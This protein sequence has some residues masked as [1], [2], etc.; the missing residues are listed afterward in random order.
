MILTM[1]YLVMVGR[2]DS[3]LLT[4]LADRWRLV[5]PTMLLACVTTQR[6][7]LLLTQFVLLA[8]QQLGK[9]ARHVSWNCRLVPYRSGSALGGS[10]S[11]TV[12]V[13]RP[14]VGRGPLF[15]LRMRMLQLGTGIEGSLCPI[16][17]GLTLKGPVV[18]V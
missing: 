9:A 18:T 12:T 1:V 11:S 3:I 13:F 5:M 6:Q 2:V 15:L 17:S 14:L 7:L 4:V 8:L 16:G 10:G